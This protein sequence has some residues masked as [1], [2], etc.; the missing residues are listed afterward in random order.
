M[1]CDPGSTER[2]ALDV[3]KSTVKGK[4]WGLG[5]LGITDPITATDFYQYSTV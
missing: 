4:R 2:N 3:N 5:F 1:F